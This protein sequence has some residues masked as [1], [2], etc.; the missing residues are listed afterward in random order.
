MM[1]C[2]SCMTNQR[3]A[4]R[5]RRHGSN[6]LVTRPAVR[7]NT[8]AGIDRKY[9]LCRPYQCRRYGTYYHTYK[10]WIFIP[11]NSA[12]L[13]STLVRAGPLGL[14]SHWTWRRKS[15][16]VYYYYRVQRV[17]FL[18]IRDLQNRLTGFSIWS[19]RNVGGGGCLAL[20]ANISWG[21]R[22]PCHTV[23][24]PPVHFNS[25]SREHSFILKLVK[26][27]EFLNNR[28]FLLKK[29]FFFFEGAVSGDGVFFVRSIKNLT[30]N[31]FGMGSDKFK[32]FGFFHEIS[33]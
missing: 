12:K 25:V 32:I 6:R 22:N 17:F 20:Q 4:L 33:S 1:Q 30:N 18:S 3:Y 14:L 10:P 9:Q 13:G 16:C 28:L 15:I 11:S 27:V 24:N 5:Q 21:E 19:P 8:T 31:T 29:W 2:Y 7:F 26:F 23:V